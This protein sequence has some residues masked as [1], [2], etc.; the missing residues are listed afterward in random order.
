V[1]LI[2]NGLL[3]NFLMSR[4]PGPDLVQ[5]N[6]H[7]RTAFL[8]E[9]RPMISNLFFTSSA[10]VSAE[11]LKKKFLDECKKNGNKWCL[12]VREMDNPVLGVTEPGDASELLMGA[13]SGAATGDR[14]PLLIYRV[15]VDDGQ[16]SLVRGAR[17]SGL[18][19]RSIRNIDGIGN[20]ATAFSFMA[21]QQAGLAGTALGAFGSAD[22][23]V[24]ATV[25]APSLL[26]DD[27]E[28]H[29][30]RGEPQRLPMVPP[31]PMN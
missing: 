17:L 18:T 3:L 25:I 2:E 6:G 9:P 1:Q 8:G 11:D 13:A 29:G 4:R 31:P 21:S 26:F 12:I 27:V 7:G 5:T 10:A 23:G 22:S 28:V 16:E 15:N 20:D 30:A 19:V 24:P 14:V